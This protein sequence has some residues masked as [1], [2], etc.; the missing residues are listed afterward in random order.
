MFSFMVNAFKAANHK[1]KRNIFIDKK[2]KANENYAFDD[3][4]FD[5]FNL[6]DDVCNKDET[7]MDFD[8]EKSAVAYCI[9]NQIHW[10][11]YV[12]ILHIQFDLSY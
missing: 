9:L 4:I 11:M 12:P 7:N 8:E 3:D 1:E 6:D 2:R 5:A 10:I